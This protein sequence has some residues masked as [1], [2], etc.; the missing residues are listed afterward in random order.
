ML[1][2]WWKIWEVEEVPM[3]RSQKTIAKYYPEIPARSLKPMYA[4]NHPLAGLDTAPFGKPTEEVEN[5][6]HPKK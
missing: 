3:D 6:R 4:E 2:G 1:V 5:P